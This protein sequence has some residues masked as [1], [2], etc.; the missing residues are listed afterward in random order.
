MRIR[1]TST[2]RT[3]RY[4]RLAVIAATV[5]LATAIGIHLMGGGVLN[6]ISASYYTSA[7][8]AFVGALSAI[9]LALLA[10]SG[11]SVEQ[12]L[13]DV[14]AVLALVLAYVPAPVSGPAC[15]VEAPC[16]PPEA[17]PAVVTNGASVA[18]VVALGA[19]TAGVLALVQGTMTRG[20][21]LTVAAVLVLDAGGLAWA[22][23]AP[24][25]FLSLAHNAA[26]V[27]FFALV[28]VVAALAAW[29]PHGRDD[30]RRGVRIAYAIVAAGIASTLVLL[31]VALVTGLDRGAFPVVLAGESLALALFA[32]FWAVQTVELWNDAD[33]T[34]WSSPGIRADPSRLT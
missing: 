12:G 19:V 5:F 34:V 21:A 14:A 20:V 31:V 8:P 7:G 6:S 17:I 22:L 26:A 1:T 3:Y 15:G 10:L 32:V 18:V 9:A 33:P 2:Q 29:R 4:V 13:L 25:S 11:R 23:I 27:A 30:R 24:A 16:V 28:A